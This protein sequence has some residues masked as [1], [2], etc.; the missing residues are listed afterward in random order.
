MPEF[1]F[2]HNVVYPAIGALAGMAFAV[3]Y[4]RAKFN[5]AEARI[6]KLEGRC[7]EMEHD[8]G[9]KIDDL[10]ITMTRV[11]TKVDLLIDGRIKKNEA[12]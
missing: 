7:D 8:T 4:Y 6:K 1:N 11:E 3:G 2:I 9:K 5:S 10:N 12:N